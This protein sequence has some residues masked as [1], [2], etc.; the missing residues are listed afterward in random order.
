MSFN[1]DVNIGGSQVGSGG[2]GGGPGGAVVGG[3]IGGIILLIIA[4]IFGINPSDLPTNPGGGGSDQGQVQPGGTEQDSELANCKTGADANKN[5]A[6]RVKATVLAVNTFWSQELP[7]YKREYT[8]A[9]T[10]LY[11]GSTQS[12]CGT[13]SNQV[14]PFYCPLDKQVYIDASFF[15]ILSD[16]FGSSSGPL[17]Q[18]YVVA[19]EYGH[20]VQ[21]LLG[22]L[23]EAQ[24]DPKGE[25]SGGVRIELMADCL[26]GVWANHATETKGES[27]SGGE[28]AFL[29]PLT[30]QD[31]KDAL[32]AASSVGDDRIQEKTQGRVSPESWTHGSA[33]ARQ[34]WFTTGYKSGDLNQCD[35][36][37]PDTV[38]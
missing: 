22:L 6:C 24:K 23:D 31:I 34:K 26:A 17:A 28:V 32:S 25:Q 9:T 8:P 2:S 11:N 16:Q 21:D 38:E 10:I 5:D 1:D 14:G 18:E 33:A 35:T 15:Q 13:A 27:T 36:L 19:H 4:L 30:D 37:S 7:K 29:K 12:A 3:G 20:H